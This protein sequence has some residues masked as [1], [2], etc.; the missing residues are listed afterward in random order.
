M[1]IMDNTG[2]LSREEKDAIRVHLER[3]EIR[4]CPICGDR[5]LNINERALVMM[6]LGKPIKDGVVFVTVSCGRCKARQFYGAHDIGLEGY[7]EPK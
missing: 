7:G 3:M 6:C 2:I 1:A 5:H 4:G